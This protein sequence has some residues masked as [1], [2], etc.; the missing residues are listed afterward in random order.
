MHFH[1]F[2][3]LKYLLPLTVTIES[4]LVCPGSGSGWKNVVVN[5]KP[6]SPRTYHTNTACM[7]DHL[8]VFCG[9]E[10]GAAPV[11]DPKLH[12]FDT[13]LF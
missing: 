10:A 9:G 3:S 8:Y 6:P 7:G 13:G 1:H 5:G 11:S 4:V 2:P 12:I